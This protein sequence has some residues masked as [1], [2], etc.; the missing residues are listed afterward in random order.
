MPKKKKPHRFACAKRPCP[1]FFFFFVRTDSLQSPLPTDAWFF[2][3]RVKHDASDHI[4]IE[5]KTM[6]R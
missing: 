4:T 5:R 2:L 1:I 3:T 6:I